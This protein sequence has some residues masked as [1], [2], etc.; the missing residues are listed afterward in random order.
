MRQIFL[1][2]VSLLSD[3]NVFDTRRC[4]RRVD[5]NLAT[6]SEELS[7]FIK[8]CKWMD[9]GITREQYRQLRDILWEFR[10]VELPDTRRRDEKLRRLT[11]L[12][13]SLIEC[14]TNNCMAFTGPHTEL[15]RC[16]EC[17]E[18]RYFDDTSRPRNSF[19]YMPVTVALQYMYGNPARSKLLETYPK[20]FFE[21]PPDT[22][23][24]R[25]SD[26]WAGKRFRE[27]RREGFF[28]SSTDIAFQ[29]QF[30]GFQLTKRNQHSTTPVILL[31]FNLPP[32]IRHRKQ[33]IICPF[34][35][36]GPAKY[37]DWD[38]FLQPL[39]DELKALGKP[40]GIDTYSAYQRNRFGLRAYAVLISGDGPAVSEAIGMK[41]PG[42]AIDPCRFC[43]MKA[44][45]AP[46]NHWYVPHPRDPCATS[47]QLR[48]RT[49]LKQSLELA[50]A[51]GAGAMEGM[52]SPYSKARLIDTIR[53]NQ[54]N[55]PPRSP[56]PPLSAKFCN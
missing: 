37:K 21:Q 2:L 19:P 49:N 13:P 1:I 35:I 34:I 6:E 42:N 50:T 28:T 8:L 24:E 17:D 18:P 7:L 9:T 56:N 33:N 14:C 55:C 25:I 43:V 5:F 53:D 48:P 10:R 20:P 39:V 36:P 38:S 12:S 41:A 52:T 46:N 26:W 47:R 45:K 22:P 54:K 27:L 51:S 11:G 31:N 4:C 30:D 32:E 44:K 3:S 15:M 16:K 40:N 29:I 23:P